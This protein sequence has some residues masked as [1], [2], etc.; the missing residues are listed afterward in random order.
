MNSKINKP[1]YFYN[2]GGCFNPNGS[3]KSNNDCKY[4]HIKVN[5]PLEK[6]QHLK[7][8]CKYYHLRGYCKNPYCAF[9]HIE[10]S[11][12]RW[13]KYFNNKIFPGENYTTN[14]IWLK[15]LETQ[16]EPTIQSGDVKATLL[17]FMLNLLEKNEL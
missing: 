8:P 10:L 17:M 7:A 5:E 11:K 2:T 1:C 3:L 13:Q 14:F 6:P 12:H 15:A 16:E 4:L 9:G